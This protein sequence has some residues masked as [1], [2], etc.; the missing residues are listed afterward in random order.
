MIDESKLTSLESDFYNLW[1]RLSKC[2][3]PVH[4]YRFHPVRQWRF[5]FS[6]PD[7]M[8]AV[9]MEGGTFQGGRHTRGKGFE[10]DCT[11]YNTATCMGWRILRFT[12]LTLRE[13]PIQVIEQVKSLLEC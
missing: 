4:D 3:L 12:A 2:E 7:K 1:K 9:E 11:K 10:G 5:D 8:V 6:W 13:Q